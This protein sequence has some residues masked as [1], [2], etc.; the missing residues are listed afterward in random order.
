M[1]SVTVRRSI[2]HHPVDGRDQQDQAR[3][4]LAEQPAEAEDDRALVLA[5]DPDRRGGERPRVTASSVRTSD[6]GGGHGSTSHSSAR[7][8]DSV[9]PCTASTTTCS[10]SPS[11][12]LVIGPRS[13]RT[14]QL[15][16]DEH[17]ADRRDRAP[18]DADPA[19][20]R[21]RRRPAAAGA[22]TASALRPPIDDQ[23]DRDE[24]RPAR[25]ARAPAR[26]CRPRR[27][28]RA[29]AGEGEER[30]AGDPE[31]AVGSHMRLGDEQRRRPAPTARRSG[32]S[33]PGFPAVHATP[34][35]RA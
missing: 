8:T 13:P 6:D 22:Q 20:Q 27:R 12:P 15:A 31:N 14:P 4:L 10:P 5:Q 7:R 26:R 23:R 19:D 3:A 34:V 11:A 24:R 18:D 28:P 33:L 16:L 17:V 29:R 30:N 25:P 9:R 35:A 2:A 32:R 1:S 21:R